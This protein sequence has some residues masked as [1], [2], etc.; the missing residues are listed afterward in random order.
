MLQHKLSVVVPVYNAEKYLGACIESVICQKVSCELEILL[1]DDG[2]TDASAQIAA[3]YQ[4]NYENVYWFAGKNSGPSAARNRGIE[5]ATG[6]YLFFMDSD[7]LLKSG[8]LEHLY[9]AAVEKD[10]DIA[11][12]GFTQWNEKTQKRVREFLREKA[13]YTGIEWIHFRMNQG[14]WNNQIW[15]G[16]YKKEFLMKNGIR[17]PEKLWIYEDIY[18]SNFEVLKAERIVTVSEYGYLYRVRENS[19][20]H[21]KRNKEHD[22]RVCLEILEDLTIQYQNMTKEARRAMGRVFYEI[23]SMVLY[24]IGE[25]KSEN[26]RTYYQTIQKK[27][28]F[29]ILGKSITTKKELMKY[30]IFRCC[31]GKYYDLIKRKQRDCNE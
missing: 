1:M 17:F 30:L 16:L 2:S 25:T 19:L 14:D 4:S 7:D 5:Q 24:Y 31:I 6:D 13:T 3:E 22:I 9:Q 10:A 8:Y 28:I 15:C 11:Y 21:E 12:A 23:I 26:A 29:H 20:S 18:F 27:C